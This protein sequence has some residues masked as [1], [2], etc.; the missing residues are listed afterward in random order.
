MVDAVAEAGIVEKTATRRGRPNKGHE[1]GWRV[2]DN[3]IAQHG[4][5]E[6]PYGFN[7]T[8]V[9]CVDQEKVRELFD[10]ACAEK[11]DKAR[12]KAWERF[13]T[14]P[15]AVIATGQMIAEDQPDRRT[16]LWRKPA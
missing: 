8:A 15:K 1:M 11:T 14:G 5:I 13:M 3:A 16:L 6:R 2:F 10:K 4:K 7:S 9:L 12:D